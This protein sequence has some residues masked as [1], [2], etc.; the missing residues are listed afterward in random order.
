A[1]L[2]AT[3][4]NGVSLKNQT[5]QVYISRGD[6]DEISLGV[7]TIVESE[8]GDEFTKITGYDAMYASL[9][10][11]YM[12]TDGV[13][14]A[15][16]VL[17]DVCS[18]VGLDLVLPTVTDV[19]VE[20]ADG[21]T[22]REMIGYMAALLGCNARI[23]DDGALKLG[24]FA[25]SEVELG[26]SSTYSGGVS[27]DTEDWTLGVINCTATESTT[28]DDGE[29]TSESV[30][31][32]SGDG[33]TGLA[34]DNPWM[35]QTLLDSIFDEIG[36]LTFRGGT[37]SLIGDLR[38]EPNDIVTITDASGASYAFPIM[39]ITHSYDGGLKTTIAAYADSE[40]E[41]AGSV[42]GPI[43]KSIEKV[44]SDIGVFSTLQ[45]ENFKAT[46]AEISTLNANVANITTL[47]SGS[48]GTGTLQAIHLS[49]DNVVIDD[50]VITSAMIV[51]LTAS[52]I[53]SGTIYT[54]QVTIQTAE[55]DKSLVIADGT[56]QISD[57]TYV[58]VQIGEDA[59]G[60]Y[61]LYLWNASGSL[62][63]NAQGLT[64]EGLG[65][66]GAIIKDLN[67][68]D[69]AAISGTKLDIQSVAS[70]LSEDGTLTVNASNVVINETTLDVAYTTVITT[71]D[72]AIVDVVNYYA[73][74]ESDTEPP[75]DPGEEIAVG[76]C[77]EAVCDE[78]ACD[79][80]ICWTTNLLA[81]DEGQYLWMVQ[82]LTV[83][84]GDISWTEPVCLTDGYV[85]NTTSTLTTSLTVIQ[86]QI[87]AKVWQTDIDTAVN[88]LGEEIDT[89]HDQYSSVTQNVDS[90]V[91]AVGEIQTEM[92]YLGDEITAVS[93][94]ITQL[95][96][97]IS[98]SVTS[99]T[100]G[101]A[102]IKLSVGDEDAGDTITAVTEA[103][104]AFAN[105]TSAITISAGTVLFASNTLLV[106]SDNFTLDSSGDVA[107]TGT[108]TATSG[109]IGGWTIGTSAIYNGTTSMTSTTTGTY[110]GTS[111]IRQYASSS[112]YI[113][114]TGGVL[115]AKGASISGTITATGGTIGG[116]NI[117]SSTLYSTADE[118]GQYAQLSNTFA[119][120][121]Y[122]DSRNSSN[123]AATTIQGGNIK[124]TWSSA[125]E[126]SPISLVTPYVFYLG[127]R[128]TDNYEYRV[129]M[130]ATEG[131]GLICLANS[132]G[133]K[134]IT[135]NG[136]DGTV[137]NSSDRAL[138]T[139]I[140]F[141]P[142]SYETML[143]AMEPVQY[144]L[145]ADESG[146]MHMG[147]IANDVLAAAEAA[148]L[149]ESDIAWVTRGEDNLLGLCYS[150][151][152]PL[153]HLKIK[154]LEQ[155]I[156]QLEKA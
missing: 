104:K 27:I 103:R 5:G 63:W 86:G 126:G 147:Y 101:T 92:G 141:L 154:K 114:M 39:S 35:T 81:A 30:T 54:S 122:L 60:D 155:R 21:Y 156:A 19:S 46:Y 146:K 49:S 74:G 116:F 88:A 84:D 149:E 56:I 100:D 75:C 99:N 123:L 128:G 127:V 129:I 82:K 12:P 113:N 40:T 14:T 7:F 90:I 58:R 134:T 138:K 71:L 83:T 33:S 115:T 15:T 23:N 2:T 57:G 9:E 32:T 111:G 77:D 108:I 69:D 107:I 78:A 72:D 130:D 105:D 3:I 150:E 95:A 66:N 124:T 61:N 142:N 22:C 6:S 145:I 17:E 44:I 50:A 140:K 121:T 41:S 132:S 10:W 31:L 16:G 106:E 85:R 152:I 118:S 18:Q 143:D 79:E 28:D 73:L 34:L 120:F 59:S 26:P 67:V 102:S 112:A 43:T 55:D 11:K 131:Y 52:K 51:S 136:S 89:I 98:L 96:D 64:A 53:T 36:G 93:S 62:I 117:G 24:W 153:L 135:L 47:L 144:S 25:D 65:G 148:G 110:I 91:S 94:E 133:T 76:I 48:I 42:T 70:E 4:V 139:N 80:T 13:S 97:S 137:T 68:A 109:T 29:T 119:S 151:F 125:S 20:T 1:T 38:L 45:A 37:V 8:A 87:E